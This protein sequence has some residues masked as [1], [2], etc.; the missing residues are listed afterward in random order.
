MTKKVIVNG[1]TVSNEL[2]MLIVK[3]VLF[4]FRSVGMLNVGPTK[5]R[6]SN[7][8]LHLVKVFIISSKSGP[9]EVQALKLVYCEV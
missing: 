1:R 2:L 5:N 9:S 6:K 7:L 8:N 3:L 4:L